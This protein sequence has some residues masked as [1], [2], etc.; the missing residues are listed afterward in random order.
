MATYYDRPSGLTK[1]INGMLGRLASL[2]LAPRN[3]IAVQVRGRKS[4]KMRSNVVQY[5]EYEG[6]RY[7]VAP[8]GTTEWVRNVRAAGGEAALKHG[9]TQQVRLDEL[10]ESERAPIIEAYL[11]TVPAMVQREFGVTRESPRGEIERIAPR[12]PVFKITNV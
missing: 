6:A 10:P 3:T 11:K 8:R 4:G 1:F 7:L 5:V 9:R 12:H 2:G